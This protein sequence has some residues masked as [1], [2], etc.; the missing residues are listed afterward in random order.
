MVLVAVLAGSTSDEKVYQK[1][2][3]VL[4]EHQIDHELRILSAHR[5]PKELEEYVR[6]TDAQVF[7]CVAGLSAALPGVVASQTKKPVI[8]VPVSAKLG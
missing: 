6:T 3:D 7:I 5:N 4:K 8:G 1:A 2:L